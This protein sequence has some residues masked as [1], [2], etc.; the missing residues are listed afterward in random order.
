MLHLRP[1]DKKAF[2]RFGVL[3][4]QVGS[5]PTSRLYNIL[6]H[7]QIENGSRCQIRLNSVLPTRKCFPFYFA[8]LS[9]TSAPLTAT[10]LAAPTFLLLVRRGV[11]ISRLQDARPFSARMT[12]VL[13]NVR[14]KFQRLL[15]TGV[16]FNLP[17]GGLPVPRPS[18]DLSQS[19]APTAAA[20]ATSQST[21]RFARRD[22]KKLL[23]SGKRSNGTAAISSKRVLM[24]FGR[25]NSDFDAQSLRRSEGESVFNSS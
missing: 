24:R 2:W 17:I 1:I 12:T 22:V 8:W 9:A 4:E 21:Q 25:E 20:T 5:P 15:M 13:G 6:Q 18:G 14:R 10:N 23:L 7:E 19:M 3:L 16:S 11:P